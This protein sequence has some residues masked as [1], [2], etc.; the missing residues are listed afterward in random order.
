[1]TGLG[2]LFYLRWVFTRPRTWRR[3][4]LEDELLTLTEFPSAEE[5][6]VL[7]ARAL[8]SER[9]TQRVLAEDRARRFIRNLRRS[10]DE[11]S[12]RR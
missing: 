12:H 11:H 2:L 5:L 3:D 9:R 6:A 7:A 1:M 4:A 10:P 8:S